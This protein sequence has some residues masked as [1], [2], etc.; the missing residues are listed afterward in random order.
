MRK[1]SHLIYGSEHF[2][3]SFETPIDEAID[4][5]SSK[6]SKTGFFRL[7][8]QGM[9]G[10]VSKGYTKIQRVI[11]MFVNSFP[12][13]FVGSFRA[14][15]NR[16]ILSGVF[17]LGRFVQVFMSI[18]FGF[19]VLWV[20]IASVAVIA[21]PSETWFFPLFGILMFALGVG[22]VKIGK[23]RSHNDKKWLT[24]NICNAINQNS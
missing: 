16:T 15:G 23:W 14:E 17:R 1:F 7:T 8:S 9:V 11:P 19:I 3:L 4:R 5:L 18:W 21:M 10:T 12:P 6:V 13:I 22:L 2:E 20:L 24:E